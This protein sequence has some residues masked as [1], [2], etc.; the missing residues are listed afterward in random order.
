MR[1]Y[2]YNQDDLQRLFATIIERL[3]AVDETEHTISHILTEICSH[4]KFGCGFV[5]EADHTGTFF[6]KES[7]SNYQTET[8]K[9]TFKLDSHLKPAEQ[10]EMLQHSLFYK[11]LTENSPE[12]DKNRIFDSNS[13]MMVPV[14]N[15]E[16]TPIGLVGIMDRR[17][18]ILLDEQS[19][20]AAKMVLNLLA[21][22]VKIRI[23]QRN[24]EYARQTLT[25]ILDNSGIDIYVTDYNTHEVLY[26][27]KS[28]AE[29]Y[30]G[31][32][33]LIGRKCWEVLYSDKAGQCEYCPQKMLVDEDGNPSKIYSWDYQRPFDGSWFRVISSAFRW[34]DGRLAHV[35]S[36]VDITENKTNEATIAKIANYDALTNLPNR[37][38]LLND[39][40]DALRHLAGDDGRGFLLFFDLD[41]FKKLNDSMGH[42]AGD[43]LLA[44]IGRE[45]SESPWTRDHCYRY[46]GDEFVLLYR[47]ANREYVVKVVEHLLQRFSQPWH[48][49]GISPVCM[50]S[51]GV[52][53][54][55]CN[56]GTA[57]ELVH[58]AD[59]MMYKAKQSGGGIA[60]FF[61]GDVV[62]L[63]QQ[64]PD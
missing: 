13:F 36:S 30:G 42:Q 41:K 62:T 53:E 15:Q 64:L 61:D 33:K 25:G 23:Y 14:I 17:R 50:A 27:N 59:L 19:V 7:Y 57:E 56:G 24:L 9:D 46:G 60:C 35:I 45:M 20:Q 21:N 8:L 5:Y 31:L 58:N 26:A 44:E 34:F 48:L 11:A 2:F 49:N 12:V 28:M 10:A 22:H 47:N 16:R 3:S 55:P 38:K 4:F 52:A 6:L 29:P 1:T 37:R 18:N 32:D 39:C 54:Y 40:R 63:K 43:R 51:I